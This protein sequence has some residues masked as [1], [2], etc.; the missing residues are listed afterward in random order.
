M[1]DSALIV[2]ADAD[3]KGR[4][5]S[6]LSAVLRPV[7]SLSRLDI[8]RASFD[9]LIS[10]IGE[11]RCMV[12]TRGKQTVEEDKDAMLT[13]SRKHEHCYVEEVGRGLKISKKPNIGDRRPPLRAK[14]GFQTRG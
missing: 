9:C 5:R 4:S 11:A 2:A 12:W 7:N 14:V 13:F 1:V 10:S 6:S 8:S 3:G